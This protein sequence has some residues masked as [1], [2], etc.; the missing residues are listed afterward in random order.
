MQDFAVPE[1]A[2]RA[3]QASQNVQWGPQAPAIDVDRRGLI[4][5]AAWAAP[6]VLSAL[7][8]PLAASS[9]TIN[10][11]NFRTLGTCGTLGV[12]G[13]G[14]TITAAPT[15]PLPVGTTLQINGTG[16]ANIGLFSVTGGSAQVQVLSGTART[17]I[18][19]AALPA[20]A[21]LAART[22]LSI[23]VAFTLSATLSLPEGYV[24]GGEAKPSAQ[25]TSTLVFCSGT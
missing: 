16:V 11:G 9:A 3:D 10:V 21:T 19:T 1:R 8:A 17:V 25:V 20:G 14:F 12:L 6:V 22:T 15:A 2:S 23:S 5:S 24:G 7:A 18:L 4:K 13:P